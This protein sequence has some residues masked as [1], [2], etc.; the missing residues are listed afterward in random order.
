MKGDKETENDSDKVLGNGKH[1]VE[2][3]DKIRDVL[4]NDFEV[5]E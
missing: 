1:T 4:V 5:N 2:E 3:T